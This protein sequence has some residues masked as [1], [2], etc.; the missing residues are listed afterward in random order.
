MGQFDH[1]GELPTLRAG[2][3]FDQTLHGVAGLCF[4]AAVKDY[5]SL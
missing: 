4:Y 1:R 2:Y 5:F 3:K